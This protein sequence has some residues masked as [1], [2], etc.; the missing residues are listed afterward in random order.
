MTQRQMSG[1]I[2]A[3]AR[4]KTGGLPVSV[5]S[6]RRQI[7]LYPENGTSGYEPDINGTIRLQLPSTI[8]FLDTVNSYLSFRIKVKQNGTTP[9]ANME[10]EIR[11]DRHSTSWIRT[12]SICSS[13]GSQLEHIRGTAASRSVRSRGLPLAN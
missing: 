9:T 4:Y 1:M 2:P 10:K 5:D 3:M 8:G 11:L 13:A 12:F 6:L 7:Q